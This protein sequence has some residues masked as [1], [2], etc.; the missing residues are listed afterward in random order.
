MNNRQISI[1]PKAILAFTVGWLGLTP[2]WAA[3]HEFCQSYA[4]KAIEDFAEA[5]QEGCLGLSFPVWSMDF[6]HHYKWC[7]TVSEADVRAGG[8][9]RTDALAQCLGAARQGTI[10]G[11]VPMVDGAAATRA[12][13]E[14]PCRDYA[15]T[16]VAQQTQ[17]VDRGCGFTG[18]SWNANPDDHFNWCLHGENLKRAQGE[19]H[20]RQQALDRCTAHAR[21]SGAAPPLDRGQADAASGSQRLAAVDMADFPGG[22]M[23]IDAIQAATAP[24]PDCNDLRNSLISMI[25]GGGFART[26]TGALAWQ[27]AGETTLDLADPRV[28][29]VFARHKGDLNSQIREFS[30]LHQGFRKQTLATEFRTAPL[31]HLQIAAVTSAV[32]INL[33]PEK[34]ARVDRL[35]A[36]GVIAP[37]TNV[38][39]SAIAGA[40]QLIADPSQ[41]SA[42][43]IRQ[44]CS[45]TD[46]PDGDPSLETALW[47][48]GYAF[49]LGRNF[50]WTQGDVYLEY[51]AC[52]GGAATSC[53]DRRLSGQPIPTNR[54]RLV[55][56]SQFAWADHLIGVRLPSTLPSDLAVGV[57][58]PRI[59][60]RRA[61]SGSAVASPP[62]TLNHVAPHVWTLKTDSGFDPGGLLFD[63]RWAHWQDPQHVRHEVF[64]VWSQ[65]LV[66]GA[67]LIQINCPGC[68]KG[69]RVQSAH[70]ASPGDN[71][72]VYGQG[73][74]GQPG[75]IFLTY[76]N[77][78]APGFSP[79]GARRNIDIEAGET[80][81]WR[82]DRIHIR[83]K[84]TATPPSQRRFPHLV[85]VDRNGRRVSGRYGLSFAPEMAERV[86][87]GETWL[88][89][90]QGEDDT[91]RPAPDGSALILSHPTGGCDSFLGIPTDTNERGVDRFFFKG[92]P[93]PEISVVS[94]EFAHLD[95]GVSEGQFFLDWSIG[96]AREVAKSGPLGFFKY[97]AGMALTSG[98]RSLA[99]DNGAFYIYPQKV[100]WLDASDPR[101]L[102]EWENTCTGPYADKTIKYSARFIL[103]GP[104]HLLYP[105]E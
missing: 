47:E 52:G 38:G 35:Q 100:N 31:T 18:P 20:A 36:D 90:A 60:V 104:K 70:L 28:S 46:R 95:P 82:D 6:D 14:R 49:L 92:R 25:H 72:Y 17:N 55:P 105:G 37:S 23:M 15:G 99:G 84:P 97:L 5:Q 40:L 44:V 75:D 53:E 56:I 57:A 34:L 59:W 3:D 77:P 32:S 7:R 1:F 16:A 78:T 63:G 62:V 41:A 89:L 9:L 54:L 43:N 12:A 76:D 45:L 65:K 24:E 27:P 66:Q 22:L 87:S 51:E 93:R 48:D 73:F 91:F 71:I 74:G 64:W 21:E 10:T 102:V 81:W 29:S 98:L 13:L 101:A 30:D 67:G 85:I 4:Y 61:D 42:A 39:T 79:Q 69:R 8:K 19:N 103:S 50:G 2:G 26:A 83:V 80:D 33:R 11:V 88:D 68:P 86:V 96:L 94:A 58:K